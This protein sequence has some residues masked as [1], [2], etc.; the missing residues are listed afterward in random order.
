MA[1]R[2][3]TI[4]DKAIEALKSNPD[5]IRYSDLVRSLQSDLPEIP[6]NTIHGTIWNLDARLPNEIYK[7][8]RGLF[9]HTDFRPSTAEKPET[10]ITAGKKAEEGAFYQPFADW[11]VNDL[12][13]C[14]KAIAL[15]GN[16]FRDKW[17]TPDVI[18]I[19]EPRKS[20]IIKPATEIV[21]AELKTDMG[22]LI[23]AFGQACSYKLF[24]HKSYIGFSE[25]A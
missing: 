21:A 12:E 6:V 20:D 19:R 23:T 24:S 2:K 9:R 8:V 14:T 5:G 25:S 13:E 3:G 16:R 15:G 17:G 7:P 4:T 22:N 11:L 18:G 10:A 1:T